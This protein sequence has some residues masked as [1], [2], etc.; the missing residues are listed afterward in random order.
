[1]TDWTNRQLTFNYTG[2]PFHLSSVTNNNIGRAVSFGYTANT[3]GQLDLTSVTD[4]EGKTSRYVYDTNHQVIA[5]LDALNQLVVTN[6]YDSFGRVATQYTQG[7]INKMWQVFWSG[8]RTTV[9]DP[10]GGQQQYF[11]D[12]KTRQVGFQDALGN[13][14]QTVYDGQDHV[15]ITVSPLNETN[16][17]IYDGNQNVIFSVDPLGFTN[18]FV[19]DA[20]NNLKQ[21]IDA[22]QHTNSFSYNNKFQLTNSVNAVGD[23]VSLA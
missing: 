17:S 19:Y 23:T 1:V 5:T 16:Q 2:S 15:V 14:S 11:Y 9:I 22:R 7:D 20:Q 4:P 3:N 6:V 8:F 21:I 13:L 18:Q 12:D 10:V